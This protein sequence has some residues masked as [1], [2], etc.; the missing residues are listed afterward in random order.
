MSFIEIGKNLI[1]LSASPYYRPEIKDGGI[2]LIQLFNEN[3]LLKKE[4]D[5]I[6]SKLKLFEL[7]KVR[8]Q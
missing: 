1:N 2:A 3:E 4:N 8:G 5:L 7:A 6:K